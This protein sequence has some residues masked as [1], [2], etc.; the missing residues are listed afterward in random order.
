MENPNTEI[1]NNENRTNNNQKTGDN[2][3]KQI[4]I[5]V[6]SILSGFFGLM[7]SFWLSVEITPKSKAIRWIILITAFFFLILIGGWGR[8]YLNK[9]GSFALTVA[10]SIMASFVL[11]SFVIFSLCWLF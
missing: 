6:T 5:I 3:I 4:I 9:N 11:I 7:V 10:I 2:L 1:H 8:K